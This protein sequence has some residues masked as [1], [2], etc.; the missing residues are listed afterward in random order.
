[1]DGYAKT[2]SGAFP[3]GDHADDARRSVVHVVKYHVI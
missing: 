1:M 3:E 2:I